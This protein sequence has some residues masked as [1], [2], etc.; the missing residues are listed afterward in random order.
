MR[1]CLVL[2]MALLAGCGGPHVGIHRRLKPEVLA[3]AEAWAGVAKIAV[4]P[5]DN[6][7]LDVG[8]EHVTWY[9]AVVHEL[10]RERG[11]EVVPLVDVN[12]FM[13]KN[14][15]T[16]TGEL[17]AYQTSELAEA[18]DAHAVLYWTITDK[19]P[20][21]AFNLERADG[22]TLWT[23]GDIALSLSHVAPVGG[24]YGQED[25]GIALTLGEVLRAFPARAP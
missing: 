14:R 20:R 4:M 21:V 22:T 1:I 13:L 10:L 8:L 2:A 7:T 5:P 23:T 25:K 16:F 19:A 11:W 15:F 3:P 6:W 12:R 18:F 17:G 24:R 9:R